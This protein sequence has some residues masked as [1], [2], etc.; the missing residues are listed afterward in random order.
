MV[1]VVGSLPCPPPLLA[2]IHPH[3]LLAGL[4]RPSGPS[5]VARVS[6]PRWKSEQAAQLTILLTALGYLLG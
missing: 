2:P 1:P 6:V 5:I 4:P 3:C